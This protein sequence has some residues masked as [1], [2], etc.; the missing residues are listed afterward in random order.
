M[1]VF[2]SPQV[3]QNFLPFAVNFVLSPL[4]PVAGGTEL[5]VVVVALVVVVDVVLVVGVVD[6]PPETC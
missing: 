3:P 5:V 6:P 2:E 4:R 1:R